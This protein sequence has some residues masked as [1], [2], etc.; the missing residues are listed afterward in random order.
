MRNA[1]SV[2]WHNLR[3]WS[4]CGLWRVSSKGSNN[5]LRNLPDDAFLIAQEARLE[6]GAK[7]S[8]SKVDSSNGF[9]WKRFGRMRMMDLLMLLMFQ[10]S[11]EGWNILVLIRR[12]MAF[13]PPQMRMEILS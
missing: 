13:L 2:N 4:R 12:M 7:R 3:S 10:P 1:S 11:V 8:S 5:G 9:R 6:A